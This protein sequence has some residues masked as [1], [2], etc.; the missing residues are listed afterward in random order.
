MVREMRDLCSRVGVNLNHVTRSANVVA[1]F[2]VE[3]GVE[4]E[5]AVVDVL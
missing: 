4:R 2:L 1:D 3:S 5:V